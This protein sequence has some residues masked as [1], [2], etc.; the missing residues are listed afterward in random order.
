VNRAVGKMVLLRRLI[1][2]VLP[3]CRGCDL[4]T[5]RSYVPQ[6]PCP[7][8]LFSDLPSQTQV[9]TENCG[10]RLKGVLNGM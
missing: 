4:H 3:E 10:C 2:D 1:A 8:G 6:F 7:A 9:E 5:R